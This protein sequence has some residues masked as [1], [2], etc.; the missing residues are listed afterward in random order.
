MTESIL[1]VSKEIKTYKLNS[2]VVTTKSCVNAICEYNGYVFWDVA[3]M[4]LMYG[5]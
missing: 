2:S 1:Q 5:I 4:E 3:I